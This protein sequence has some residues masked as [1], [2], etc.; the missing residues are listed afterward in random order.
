MSGAVAVIGAGGH[1][2]VVV[3]TLEAAGL[4][5]AGVFDDDRERWGRTVLEAE[6]LGATEELRRLG[7]DRA[8]LAV[9]DN[10]GRRELARSLADLDLTWASAAHPSAVV[11]HSALIGDGSVVFAGAVVQPDARVGRHSI[12]NTCA[13][14]DH[15]CTL[16]DFVHIAPGA[17]LAGGVEVGEGALIG[18]GSAVVP[19]ISIGA[20]A[21]VGAG[22]TVVRDVAPGATVKGVPAR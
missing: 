4:A 16:G 9:G 15:D 2:K 1:G 8:L 20:W 11:H 22:S 21:T 3:S 12:I 14:V 6:I 10:R 5:V 18:I 19:G 13:S 17:R 7:I